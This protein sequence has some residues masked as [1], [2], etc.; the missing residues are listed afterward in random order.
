MKAKE[1]LQGVAYRDLEV[2]QSQH[3]FCAS[4]LLSA[5]PLTI[6][7]SHHPE[8]EK[9]ACCNNANITLALYHVASGAM[10]CFDCALRMRTRAECF[11]S[12]SHQMRVS[13]Y[14]LQ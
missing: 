3:A 13:G 5:T 2:N 6:R 8:H 10:R 12:L 14:T 4:T 1:R 11:F 9:H 7:T